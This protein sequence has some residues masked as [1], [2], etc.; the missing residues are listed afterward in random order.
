[1]YLPEVTMPTPDWYERAACRGMPVDLFLG[2]DGETPAQRRRR[3]AEAVLVCRD[4]PVREQ[5]LRTA[6]DRPEVFG[7]WGATTESERQAMRRR[8]RAA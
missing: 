8:G 3:E 6:L 1:L 2:A 5:C 4:C 7:V